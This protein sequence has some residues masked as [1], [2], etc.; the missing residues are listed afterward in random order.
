MLSLRDPADETNDLGRKG[1]AIKHVQATLRELHYQLLF[2]AKVNTRPSILGPLV[3]S[4]YML[5]LERRR[6]LQQY[7]RSLMDKEQKHLSY[8]ARAVREAD[9]PGQ[10][11]PEQAVGEKPPKDADEETLKDVDVEA[12]DTEARKKER[13]KEETR[14]RL[15]REARDREWQRLAEEVKERLRNEAEKTL[16]LE[17]GDAAAS[18]PAM[19]AVEEQAQ[20]N[21]NGVKGQGE[22]LKKT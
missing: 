1:I 14:Q 8:I 15:A 22:D 19:P 6:R 17:H 11:K 5:Q 13:E 20:T 16:V 9:R 21:N 12:E 18:I 3:G 2:D 4:S 10:S 7:G